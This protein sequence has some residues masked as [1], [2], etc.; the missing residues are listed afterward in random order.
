M[1]VQGAFHN[2]G[3]FSLIDRRDAAWAGSILLQAGGA[4]PPGNGANLDSLGLERAHDAP[5]PVST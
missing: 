4:E 3:P 1:G 5:D 2:G